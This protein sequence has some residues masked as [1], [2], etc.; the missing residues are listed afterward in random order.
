[1]S[2]LDELK[3][4]NVVRVAL[5]YV[6]VAWVIL[7]VAEL[8]VDAFA[9]PDWSMRFAIIVLALGFPVAVVFSWVFELTPDGVRR[10]SEVVGT[11]ASAWK[12]NVA[13][14]V[15]A[16]LAI[17]FVAYDRS[18]PATPP[19]APPVASR[20]APERTIAVLPFVNISDDPANSYFSDGLAEELLNLLAD[21][22]ELRVTARTSS[23]S[24]RD[25]DLD[26]PTIGD[27]L[28]VASILEGSVRKNGN[29]IR[30]TA[31][32]IDTEDGF[33]IWSETYERTLEDVFALQDEIASSVVGA[34][35]V[36]LL[37]D[38]PAIRKT[39]P[40]AYSLYLRALHF[41]RQRTP[42]GYEKALRDTKHAIEINATY[43]PAWS[44]LSS[45]Y[46]NMG[47]SGALAFD[48]AHKLALEA[49]EMSLEIDPDYPF[50]NSARAWMAMVSEGDYEA[51]AKFFRRALR[52]SPGNSII[53]GNAAVLA[54]TLGYV[55]R[56][57]AMTEESLLLDPVSTSGY[58]NLSDQLYR[59]G[60]PHDAAAAAQKAMEL[61]PGSDTARGNYA[62]S[63]I[64]AEEPQRAI[65]VIASAE[66]DFLILLVNALAY[67][68]L[69]DT[70][71]ADL[72]AGTLMVSYSDSRAFY[73][74]SVF[75]WRREFDAAF[76]WLNRGIDEQQP[77][78]GIRTDPFLRSLHDDERWSA[79]LERVGLSDEQV[80]SIDF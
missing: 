54:R 16:A 2:I 75:A 63:L 44:L 40:E 53:I 19:N 6:A 1:M 50:A 24:F 80:A 10:D 25:K 36:S 21:I 65:E 49:V 31:K 11:R 71:Q 48:E 59:A 61:T 47:I 5:L 30:V 7:Q 55:D 23:F 43:A 79:V 72:N 64:L 28:N 78:L 57:I 9:F 14:G 3:R 37:G 12:T 32:L 76:E 77:M 69:G 58:I 20:I 60:R 46:S 62:L 18:R 67:T 51:A 8:L 22:K 42:E 15:F 4:R 39:D 29:R 52:L 45:T 13:I 27:T 56:A 34:L 68:S 38:F 26:I 66:R 33:D 35:R 17:G 74:A 70:E 73:I 41:Y